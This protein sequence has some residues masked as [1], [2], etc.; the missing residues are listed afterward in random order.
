MPPAGARY[1][2]I[3]TT[4]QLR[5]AVKKEFAK[6]DCLIMAAAP[7]DYQPEKKQLSK[8]KKSDKE[9]TLPLKPT[10][11]ILKD[12][13]SVRRKKQVVVGFAL[14]TDDAIANARKKL[15][16]KKLDM[17]VVNTPGAETGFEHDTNS[18]TLIMPGKK[19]VELPLASKSQISF[20]ILDRLSTLL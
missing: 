16:E 13:A 20:S 4:S 1:I 9:L 7:A 6:A 8:I 15:K 14:E 5:T 19:P 18:V 12:I 10:V 11:D 2:T 3:E 17:I